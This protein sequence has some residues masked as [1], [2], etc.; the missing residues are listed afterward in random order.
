MIQVLITDKNL[1]VVGDPVEDWE[2]LQVTTNYNEPAAGSLKVT[3]WPEVMEQLQPGHRLV[4]LRNGEIWSAG[5]MEVPEEWAWGLGGD[6]GGQD[7]P[8]PGEVTVSFSD[9]D[10]TVA[11]RLTYPDP[12][13]T[14]SNSTQP[15]A[16]TA[17]AVNAET[18]MRTLVNVNAGPGALAARRI[19]HLILGAVAGV[20]T[21]TSLTTRFEPLGDVL[22]SVAAAGGNLVF[23]TRQIDDDLEFTVRARRDLTATARFSP[24]LN[25]LRSVAYKAS[26]PT[27][28][29]AIVGGS[30]EGDARVIVEV[31]DGAAETSWFRVERWVDN[32]GVADDS[33][34]ELTAAGQEALA[35]GAEPVQLSTVTVD[36]EDLQAGRDFGVGDLVTVQ[37]P[38]GLEVVDVVRSITLRATPTA[39]EAVASVIGSADATTDRQM[40][41]MIR[42]LGRRLGR[43]ETR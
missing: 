19:P 8:E 17:T 16:Y 23:G 37:L 43:L 15:A 11:G 5:P 40:V 21:S 33:K 22:R 30:G 2:D 18:L 20:G 41:Q 14:A 9:D 34:G 13:K 38:T 12:A 6:D 1:N 29:A 25:N 32:A 27:T 35:A 4:V 36:T 31:I 24:G 28:T 10:A 39:G 3:A 42:E 26:A 7:A